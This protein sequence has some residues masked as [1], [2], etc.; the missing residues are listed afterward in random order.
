MK[1][2]SLKTKLIAAFAVVSMASLIVGLI[3]LSAVQKTDELLA[4]VARNLAPSIDTMQHIR[5]RYYR[6]LGETDVA[7]LDLKL[8][9]KAALRR[10][11]ADRDQLLSELNA[12]MAKYEAIEFAPE[13]VEPY[14]VMKAHLGEW[15]SMNDAVWEALDEGDLQK[16]NETRAR[17]DAARR[18]ALESS[19]AM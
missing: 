7:T 2:N 19:G 16:A 15:K 5:N 13:E 9:D 12:S 14:R 10:A 17:G 6:V 4:Y 11:R 18:N 8:D 1:F 3:G